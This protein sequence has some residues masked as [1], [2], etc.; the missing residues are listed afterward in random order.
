MPEA[1]PMYHES[2]LQ[3][4]ADINQAGDRSC[5]ACGHTGSPTMGD[6]GPVCR[7]CGSYSLQRAQHKPSEADSTAAPSY[8]YRNTSDYVRTA[9]RKVA[10]QIETNVA[11]A[12]GRV[13][14]NPGDA[15]RM[16][17]GLTVNVKNVRRHETSLD[18]YYV[19]TDAGTT[20]VPYSTKFQVVPSN[21]RQ[22]SLP[23][24]GTPGGNFNYLPGNPQ[25]NESSNAI[26]HD[27][28]C[29]SC[30]RKGTMSM[31]NDKYT[32]SVCGYG[33]SRRGEN[34][35]SDN[36]Q[37]IKNWSARKTPTTAIA[38]RAAIVLATTEGDTL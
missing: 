4:E 33:A 1:K 3:T 8:Q 24:Y 14:L 31:H 15:I 20:V 30:G 10:T 19:D 25:H 36:N 9:E 5:S 6:T 22:L 29:P 37:V 27:E 21:S 28:E 32:C 17:N 26:G 34:E 16:P 12:D 2:A 11:S 23:D 35:F 7:R 13:L 18:H 38:K